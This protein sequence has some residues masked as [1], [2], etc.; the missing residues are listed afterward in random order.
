[1]TIAHNKIL[2]LKGNIIKHCLGK[3]VD[4]WNKD[5][6]TKQDTKKVVSKGRAEYLREYT[7]HQAPPEQ[8]N[9]VFTD[10]LKVGN[11][12]QENLNQV[13]CIKGDGENVLL[14]EQKLMNDG[15]VIFIN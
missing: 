5:K 2:R 11:E 8:G 15:R 3:N 1:M 9:K 14:K 10:F 7:N 4:N 6:V 13:K 12:R